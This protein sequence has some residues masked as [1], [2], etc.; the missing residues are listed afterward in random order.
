MQ[1]VCPFVS[2]DLLAAALTD[3]HDLVANF[4]IRFCAK[5]DHAL[6]HT[7]PANHRVGAPFDKHAASIGEKAV[8]A[9]RVAGR[10]GGDPCILCC[11]PGAS[12]AD[13]GSFFNLLDEGNTGQEAKSGFEVDRV[14]GFFIGVETVDHNAGAHHVEPACGVGENRA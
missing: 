9:I 14:R 6:V 7:H 13:A 8:K 4:Y 1:P 11:Q 10:D 2:G 5:V 3:Q 12:V